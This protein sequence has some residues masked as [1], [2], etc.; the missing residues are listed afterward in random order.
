MREASFLVQYLDEKNLSLESLS[1]SELEEYLQARDGT[2]SSK[3]EARDQSA[4]RQL[5]KFLVKERVRED[6]VALLLEKPKAEKTLPRALSK[7]Q[8]E[9]I[10]S[11]FRNEGDSL[12]AQRDYTFFEVIYSCGL[13]I[14]EAISLSLSSYNE[15]EETIRVI[16]KRNKERITFVGSYAKVALEEYLSV[17]RPVLAS[18]AKYSDRRTAEAR[19]DMDA[20]FLGRTG[21]RLT[22][23][24]MHKRYHALV[25]T[26]GIDSTVHTLRHSFATHLLQ[27]GANIREVQTMLGH[28]DIKTTQIY[29]HLN[30]NDLLSTFDKFSPLDEES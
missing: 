10:L 11:A 22:R 16:G 2:L 6:D 17:T 29:T 3:T 18:R 25:E 15:E 24:A 19:D 4:L 7:G 26:L 13:R 14:S 30:T 8:V 23:Q 27:G 1:L 9:E 12:I 20:L 21:H 5:F 28:S